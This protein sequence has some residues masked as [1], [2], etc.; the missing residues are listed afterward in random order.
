[1]DMDIEIPARYKPNVS[2]RVL[3]QSKK[4]ELGL[5]V[6]YE[7]GRDPGYMYTLVSG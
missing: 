4:M 2:G 7:T 5:Y 3:E 1:M 6:F